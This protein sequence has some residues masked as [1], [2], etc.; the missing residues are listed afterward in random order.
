LRTVEEIG[1][2]DDGSRGLAAIHK[3]GGLTMVLARGARPERG[4]PENA[5]DYDGP[6]DLIG[7]PRDIATGVG[8]VCRQ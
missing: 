5:M 4:M 7:S 6:I 2:L 3:A 8:A 1:A